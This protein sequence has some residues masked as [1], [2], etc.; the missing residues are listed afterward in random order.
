MHFLRGLFRD[1]P[2]EKR[3]GL[4]VPRRRDQ[5]LAHRHQPGEE[6]IARLSASDQQTP[7][8]GAA[9]ASG[10]KGE[11]DGQMHRGIHVPRIVDDQR[12]IAAHLQREDLLRLPGQLAMQMKTG[13]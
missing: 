5:P 7:G 8:A 3:L 4:G 9:L 10:N 6:G 1:K 11:L 12:V 13:G 2:A